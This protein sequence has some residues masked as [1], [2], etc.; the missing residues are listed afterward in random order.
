MAITSNGITLIDTVM[1]IKS[2][3]YDVTI[4]DLYIDNNKLVIRGNIRNKT[5]KEDRSFG[6]Y[7]VLDRNNDNCCDDNCNDKEN[8]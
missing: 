1:T 8:E 7:I 4:K 6:E 3:L 2:D 5:K